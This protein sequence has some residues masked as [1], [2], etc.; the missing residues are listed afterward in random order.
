[1]VRLWFVPPFLLPLDT[2]IA[3]TA[4]EVFLSSFCPMLEVNF[5]GV[6]SDLADAVFSGQLTGH[7]ISG[8]ELDSSLLI[9]SAIKADLASQLVVGNE[10]L[11][12]TEKAIL[13]AK[14][15]QNVAADGHFDQGDFM[16]DQLQAHL[17]AQ[18]VDPFLS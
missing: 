5:T 2:F 11:G 9:D 6:M 17:D 14:I 8:E 18:L 13:E 3:Q 1:M 10:P 16:S 4:V 12:D 15:A 7:L